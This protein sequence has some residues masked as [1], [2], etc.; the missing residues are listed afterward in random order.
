MSVHFLDAAPGQ[1]RAPLWSLAE[2]IG[3]VCGEPVQ[4]GS[5]YCPVCHARFNEK[6]SV[7]RE[8]SAEA[9]AGLIHNGISRRVGLKVIT[10]EFEERT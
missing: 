9:V 5:P 6:P 8:R 2:K 3:D 1:C 4:A 10:K 7:V